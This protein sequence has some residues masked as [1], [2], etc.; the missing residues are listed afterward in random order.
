MSARPDLC[1]SSF[2]C[3]TRSS[4]RRRLH[5]APIIAPKEPNAIHLYTSDGL[6]GPAEEWETFAGARIVRN[7]TQPTLTPVLPDPAKANGTAVIVAPGG[8][9]LML[10]IDTEGYQVAHW[11]AD[12]G[13]TAFVL[14]YRLKST[15][16]DPAAYLPTLSSYLGDAIAHPPFIFRPLP[17]RWMMPRLVWS[18]SGI[19]Q[20]NGRL[21]LQELDFGLFGGRCS[22][23]DPCSHCVAKATS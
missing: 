22:H 19:V 20:R 5:I 10:S 2:P 9:F 1:S 12:R 4:K 17:R 6:K 3:A 18:L 8:A 15:P 16:R 11:L 13:I 23:T 14:K 7:V 21:I